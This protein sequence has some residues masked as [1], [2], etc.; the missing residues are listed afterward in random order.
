MARYFRI[1][2]NFILNN[3]L[4]TSSRSAW[5]SSTLILKEI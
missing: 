1:Y 5:A 3:W 4:S 2:E